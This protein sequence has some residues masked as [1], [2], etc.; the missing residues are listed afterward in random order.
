MPRRV[1][2]LDVKGKPRR[3]ASDADRVYGI[4]WKNN[5]LRDKYLIAIAAQR[6]GKRIY[7]M[8]PDKIGKAIDRALQAPITAEERARARERADRASTNPDVK[9]GMDRAIA[10]ASAASQRSLDAWVGDLLRRGD[11]AEQAGKYDASITALR[12]EAE[13][14]PPVGMP[15]KEALALALTQNNLHITIRVVDS[16]DTVPVEGKVDHKD[17]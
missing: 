7:T 2:K 1:L 16:L 3:P 11:A 9:A 17:G 8:H 10:V 6:I 14:V 5:P 12:V 15:K 4:V 13:Y